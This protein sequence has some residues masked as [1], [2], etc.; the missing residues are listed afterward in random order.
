MRSGGLSWFW[1]FWSHFGPLEQKSEQSLYAF[2]WVKLVLAGWG[3]VGSGGVGSGRGRSGRMGGMDRSGG[4]S[5]RVG[6]GQ[7]GVLAVLGRI[8]GH[9]SRNRSNPC[10]RSG[11]LSRFWQF[12]SHFGTFEEKPEQS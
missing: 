4:G 11:G 7:I 6:S 12:W 2:R 5:D 8:L 10:M 3:Q 9:L 1:S